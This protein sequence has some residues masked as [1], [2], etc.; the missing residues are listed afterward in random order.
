MSLWTATAIAAATG[1]TASADFAATGVAFDSR[2]IGPGD[3]FVAMPGTDFDGHQFVDGAFGRGAAGA[4][5]SQP[6]SHPHVLVADTAAALNALGVASRERSK[7]RVAGVTGSVGKTGTKEALAAAL[8]RTPDVRVHRSVKSYNNHTGVPL[9]LARMPADSDYAVFEMGMNH[10]GEIAALTRMVRPH[11]AVVTTIAPAHIE[12][13]PTGLDGIADAKGEIFEGLEPDGTAVIPFDSPQRDRL[14]AAATPHAARIVTFGLGDGA[15]VRARDVIANA[16]SSTVTA[17]LPGVELCFT[18]GQAGAHWVSNALAVLAAVQALGAD[19]GA[20]A[21]ALADMEQ[22]AGR[23]A[24]LDVRVGSGTALVIDE[25]YNANPASMRATLDVLASEPGRKI[26]V[27]G[28]MR[29]LGA[30][31]DALH[32]GLAGDVVAAGVDYALLVGSGME[33]LASALEGKAEVRHVADAAT[34][35]AALASLIA[36]GDAV[37]IKGSNSVGLSALVASLKSRTA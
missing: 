13:F 9:S 35:D 37:L 26:A 4:I 10:A 25:S 14:I 31:S 30:E 3:L 22:L 5:V 33:P 18:V 29:E 12:F 19:L 6:V 15:D 23:G 27:L 7:A 17:T 32:A 36:P 21:L 34:A 2:E 28:A 20:A 11:V 16:G 1:G 8:A 24:R